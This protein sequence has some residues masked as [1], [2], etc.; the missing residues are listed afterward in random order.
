MKFVVILIKEALSA[1]YEGKMY[2]KRMNG[3]IQKI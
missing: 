2:D 1:E 3:K